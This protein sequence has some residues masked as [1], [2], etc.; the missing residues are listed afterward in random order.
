MEQ[1]GL[2]PTAFS[3]DNILSSIFSRGPNNKLT[4]VREFKANYEHEWF[5]GLIKQAVVH[6]PGAL[7]ARRTV[8]IVYPE[9]NRDPFYM[10]NIKTSEIRMDTR[11]SFKERYISGEFYRTTLSSYY[12]IILLSYALRNPGFYRQ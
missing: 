2:S 12:P 10:K 7:S 9:Y 6:S 5:I 1:I 3:T 4:M 8:F 11:I